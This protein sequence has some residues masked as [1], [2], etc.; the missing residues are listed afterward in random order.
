MSCGSH[1]VRVWDILA[2]G[3]LL[4]AFSNHQ[5]T[6][7]SICFDGGHERLLSAGLDK[8]VLL[9]LGYSL[10]ELFYCR[11]VKVYSVQDY[12]VLHSMSYPAPVLSMA[13]SVRQELWPQ[14]LCIP[15]DLLLQPTNSHIVVGMSSKLL[16]I[17]TCP[18]KGATLVSSETLP[19]KGGSYRYFMR[20]KTYKPTQVRSSFQFNFYDTRL[21]FCEGGI[22]GN[23]AKR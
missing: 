12:R 4:L 23:S 10:Y 16:N 1:C 7:T 3:K 2:G 14:I 8:S 21:C 11:Q 20:G 6:I 22:C 15:T 19:P 5:K 13:M 17:K 9:L 18:P